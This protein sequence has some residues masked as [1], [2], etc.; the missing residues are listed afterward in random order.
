MESE[1]YDYNR[2]EF[3]SLMIIQ[4]ILMTTVFLLLVLWHV[5][6]YN[7]KNLGEQLEEQYL[8]ERGAQYNNS[9]FED[10]TN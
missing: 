10:F 5:R 1:S 3:Y 8:S 7:I 6:Y 4:V 9:S 2:A